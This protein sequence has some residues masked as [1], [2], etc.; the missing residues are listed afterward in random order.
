MIRFGALGDVARTLPAF[1][2]LR[3]GYRN[4]RISWLVERKAAG[5]LADQPGIDEVL[6]FPREELSTHLRRGKLLSL[7]RE[8]KRFIR[9]LRTRRFDLVVDFHSILKSGVVALA[10]GAPQRVGYARPVA[11]ELSWLFANRRARLAPWHV[12]R[13]ERNAALVDF[14]GLETS[15]EK[16]GAGDG[17]PLRSA[18]ILSL[19]SSAQSR[20]ETR[21]AGQS[22]PIAIHPGTSRAARHK[23]YTVDGYGQVARALAGDGGFPVIVTAGPMP[24]ER[25]LAQ[26]VVE[27]SGGAARLAPETSCPAELAALYSRSRL[28]IGSDTGPLHVASLVGTPVVQILGP[29]DPVQNAPYAGTPSRSVRVPVACSPC[30]RGCAAVTCMRLIPPET[31]VTAA[32]QLLSSADADALPPAAGSLLPAAGALV[33]AAGAS[34]PAAD[35]RLAILVRAPNWTG[36]LVM[37]T[38]GFRALRQRFPGARIALQLRPELVPLMAGAPWFDELLPLSSY[39]A[40]GAALLREAAALRRRGRFDVGLCV[41][42]SFSSAL[43]MRLAGVRYVV[44][45]RRGGRGPLLHAPVTPPVEWGRRRLVPRERF[46]LELFEAIGCRGGDTRLE[47]FTTPEEEERAARLLSER[48][49]SP[50]APLVALAPG[51]SYGSSKLWPLSSFARVGDAA[52]QAGAQVILLGSPSEAELVTRLRTAMRETAEVM[53]GDLDLG[54]LKAVLRRCCVLV[55]N[56]AGARHVAVAFGVPCVVVMG[57]TSPLKTALNLEGVTVL[58]ADVECRPC[59]L[60]DCPIDHRCMTGVDPEPAIEATLARISRQG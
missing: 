13:F 30:R 22:A 14:L 43:L 21:L 42:E 39:H 7:L 41:P 54:L 53:A 18:P 29:T 51:A 40:G 3:A 6:I 32:R 55:C 37:A 58:E 50:E 27:A 10:S 28:F 33:V 48:G 23:R 47:L 9:E 17:G 57:P 24:G 59:Y 49:L 26:A 36:D 25:S 38:P 56:D 60:R 52:A 46:V 35:D 4:A 34:V 1:H 20:I 45:Y 15:Y 12:S 19:A 31:I 11:H 44:G 2:S 16:G 8:A 5:V